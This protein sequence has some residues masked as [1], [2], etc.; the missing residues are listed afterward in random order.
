MR[1]SLGL[2][3][4]KVNQRS[5]YLLLCDVSD[6]RMMLAAATDNAA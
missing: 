1:Y 4:D 5:E 3:L 2:F 6:I